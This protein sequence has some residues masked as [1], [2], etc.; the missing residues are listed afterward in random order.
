M[1]PPW[2]IGLS[3]SKELLGSLKASTLSDRAQLSREFWLSH[4]KQ[5]SSGD[6]HLIFLSAL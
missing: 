1:V 2:S 5:G 3:K 4:L 6:S